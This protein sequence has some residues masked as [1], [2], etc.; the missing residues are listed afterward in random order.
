VRKSLP[1]RI[2]RM[3]EA[4]LAGAPARARR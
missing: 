3:V 2:G 4:L 1:R